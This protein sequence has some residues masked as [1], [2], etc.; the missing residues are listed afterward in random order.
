LQDWVDESIPATSVMASPR[1]SACAQEVIDRELVQFHKTVTLRA[2]CVDV[3]VL[4]GDPRCA[5]RPGPMAGRAQA[6]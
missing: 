1:G 6:V 3:E 2:R 5:R 4:G